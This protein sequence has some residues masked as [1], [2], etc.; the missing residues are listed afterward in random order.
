[1]VNPAG[2]RIDPSL[3]SWPSPGSRAFCNEWVKVFPN[4]CLKAYALLRGYPGG[5][6][7][8]PGTLWVGYPVPGEGDGREDYT[9]SVR[10]SSRM[11]LNSSGLSICSQWLVPVT[12]LCGKPGGSLWSS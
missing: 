3:P 6:D 8:P 11:R 10:N 12:T 4:G 1:M 7:T 2:E 5:E 9:V